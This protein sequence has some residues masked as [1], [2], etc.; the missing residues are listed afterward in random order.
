M[1]PAIISSPRGTLLLLAGESLT[2]CRLCEN[3]SGSFNLQFQKGSFMIPQS[4]GRSAT[5]FTREGE[6][7]C[8]L[9]D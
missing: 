2:L 9:V 5:R 1:P 8:L 6:E 4:F 3:V 7:Q